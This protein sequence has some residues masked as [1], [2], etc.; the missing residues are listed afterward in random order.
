M[1]PSTHI[2]Q[3]TAGLSS[4]REDMPNPQETG[5]SREFSGL[6]RWEWGGDILIETGERGRGMGCGAER[7]WAL[8]GRK[9]GV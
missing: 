2:Q 1:K 9:S 7:G 4:V 8:R 3:R 6:L 5:G